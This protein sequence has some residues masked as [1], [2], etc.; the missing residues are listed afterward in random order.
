LGYRLLVVQTGLNSIRRDV[1]GQ[2]SEL[3]TVQE[4]RPRALI[5]DDEAIPRAALEVF[6]VGGDVTVTAIAS[7]GREALAAVF[8]DPPDVALVDLDLPDCPGVELIEQIKLRSPTTAVLVVTGSETRSDIVDAIRAGALG[9]LTKAASPDEVVEAVRSV[10]Q[11]QPVL[12]EQTAERLIKSIQLD[13][14][15]PDFASTTGME[16]ALSERELQIL[17]LLADGK[18]NAAI[19][20]EL[21]VSPFTVKNHVA[22]IL[23]KLQLDN[24]VQA[25][26]HAVRRGIA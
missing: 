19:A 4:G 24:R 11:G 21:S 2:E 8:E 14:V 12:S 3:N 13:E 26:V 22:N 18:D 9:Y 6:L 5:V 23:G 15:E 1:N 16:P 17:R 25:A 10:A 20:L 7:T